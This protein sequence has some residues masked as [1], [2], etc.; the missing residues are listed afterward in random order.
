MKETKLNVGAFVKAYVREFSRLN[1]FE[2]YITNT[3]VNDT[4]RWA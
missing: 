3:P 2:T 4:I 1:D